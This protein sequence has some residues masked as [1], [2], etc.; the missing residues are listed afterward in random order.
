MSRGRW[1]TVVLA[2]IVGAGLVYAGTR[3]AIRKLPKQIETYGS[4]LAQ[5]PAAL[6]LLRQIEAMQLL[7]ADRFD[8]AR[9][10]WERSTAKQVSALEKQIEAERANTAALASQLASIQSQLTAI[11]IPDKP[12]NDLP[13]AL[14]QIETYKGLIGV[15]AEKISTLEAIN[16]SQGLQ[17]TAQA[18]IID[19][20]ASYIEQ[21][22]AAQAD[23]LKKANR[24]AAMGIIV[25]IA[26]GLLL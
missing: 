19:R 3:P 20:Q 21:M 15:Q 26:A 11:S 16:T 6:Q 13:E 24:R 2:L 22:H 5:V 25:G 1:I 8:Q 10:E 23:V 18:G 12:P 4:Y 7:E 9:K 17:I 14:Q